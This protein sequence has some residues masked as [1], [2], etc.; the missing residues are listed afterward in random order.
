MEA[1]PLVP[2]PGE[3]RSWWEVHREL[4]IVFSSG[5]S[6]SLLAAEFSVCWGSLLGVRVLTDWVQPPHI[7]TGADRLPSKQQLK[8]CTET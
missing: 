3:I 6:F 1:G 8:Q 2:T 7:H 5:C 4:A